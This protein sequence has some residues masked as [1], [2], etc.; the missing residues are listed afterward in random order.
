MRS[1]RSSAG[2]LLPLLLILA[3]TAPVLFALLRV[4]PAWTL[5]VGM[6]GDARYLENVFLPETSN[7]IPFRWSSPG[8]RITV[9]GA[10]SA[11]QVF[12]LRAHGIAQ[13]RQDDQGGPHGGRVVRMES[14]GKPFARSGVQES[15]GWRVYRVLLPE[16]AL[17]NGVG[18]PEPLGL[19]I[20]S[21]FHEYRALGLAISE[22]GLRPLAGVAAPVAIPLL[23]ALLYT[24]LLAGVVG[25]LW[26]ADE[27]FF[28]KESS[29]QERARRLSVPLAIAAL[30]L[31]VWAW[32]APSTLAG[33]VP[34]PLWVLVLGGLGITARFWMHWPWGDR[35]EGRGNRGQGKA[36][37][38]VFIGLFL[39]ALA[40]LMYE[41]L[42]T[43][44]FS[45]TM[46]YHF[47]FIAI[48]VA[49][50]GMTLGAMIVYLLPRT[51]TPARA[52]YHLTLYGLLFGITT[53][54]SFL[55]HMSIPFI[56]QREYVETVVG[57]Y[58]MAL[59]YIVIAVPF[60]MSGICV[61]L[62]LTK[63]P[64][65]VSKLYGA[66][67]A[68]AAI[69]CML[70]IVTLRY[71]S[72]PTA[73]LVVALLACVGAAF[74]GIQGTRN[75]GQETGSREQGMGDRGQETGSRGAVRLLTRI[76][77]GCA[78]V[79]AVLVVLN[80]A[81]VNQQDSP[82]RLLWVRGEK[83]PKPLY[84]KW[85]SF[86][87]IT[88][89][90]NPYERVAPLGWGMSAATPPDTRARQLWLTIDAGAATAITAFHGDLDDVDHLKYDVTN[91]V[92]SIR[93][94]ARVLVVGSGG[95]RDVLSALLFGQESVT[96]VDINEHTI[97]AIN[98]EFGNFTG[99]LDTYPSVQFVHDEARS[100]IARQDEPF[101]I[102]QISLIDTWAATTAGAFVLTENSLYTIEAWDTFLE[103]LTPGGVLT[104][105][106]WYFGDRP[107]EMYRL[108][109]LAAAAL[110]RQGIET[111]RDHI[112]IVKSKEI[113]GDAEGVGTILLSKQPFSPADVA[114][115]EAVCE[116]MRFGVVLSP[117]T[118]LDATFET[119]TS[120]DNFETFVASYL[121]NI[122]PPTDDSPFFFQMLRLRDI[123]NE[124]LLEQGMMSFNMHA[125]RI[126]GYLIVIVVVLAFL[127][128]VLPLLLTL[129]G[130]GNRLQVTEGRERGQDVRRQA[131]RLRSQ[132]DEQG[133][134]DQGPGAGGAVSLFVFFFC[135]G[136]GFMLVEIS[137]MQRL[138][139][140]LG[141][142]TYS[143]SVVLFT[144]LLS[145]GLGSTLTERVG[146]ERL[147]RAGRVRFALLLAVLVVFGLLT[148]FVIGW[149]DSAQTLVRIL[150]AVAIL[151]PLGVFMG[152][153]FP[154][155]M[156]VAART[157]P[158]LAPWLW[159]VN[160]AT[161]V[162]ASVFA[163]AIALSS[164]ISTAFWIGSLFYVGALLSFSRGAR[165]G[166][167]GEGTGER[168]EGTGERGEGTGDKEQGRGGR[169]VET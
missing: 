74:F 25:L 57:I 43:R 86:S 94:D 14:D 102:I 100:Y 106:R 30:L 13:F 22:V 90:G 72:G 118:A 83:E 131:G 28:V 138:I 19:V 91:L 108:T 82:F 49:M 3:L 114:T 59:T 109:S 5:N 112:I 123:F 40:T 162:C 76:A 159:G 32:Q 111:P 47:A 60:V 113:G 68:G 20:P 125:V 79:L 2:Y 4:P 134:G 21:H 161:S 15:G 140:F 12:S 11:R 80:T 6:P 133:P 137:Q 17:V 144:L 151:F 31:I 55:T 110:Q 27:R 145:S 168:G 89:R 34:S 62:A 73:V 152:M 96:G 150:I 75:R 101:D 139:V 24:W 10:S 166:E 71:T 105:S 141:H 29:T 35:G 153:A 167:R 77:L 41:N 81:L 63:F 42:L 7:G 36:G 165:R 160:G 120:G 38:G 146:P 156:K 142:P 23:R 93:S 67:L 66:D 148:P 126:L 51:F 127:F 64:R 46:W 16:G 154:L 119:L 99:Y 122:A 98:N 135:I 50:F 164:S 155:G 92:H 65:Q 48:S 18:E 124:D 53:V 128:I 58:S 136:A 149:F 132:E 104:V 130:R 9:P 39:V 85:N 45:V 129:K 157:S 26:Y 78:G 107:G 147:A 87:R 54:L 69:G 88:I 117:N 95:G 70:V 37:R 163:V 143:L 115:I 158:D 61:T 116:R 103:H 97:D 121:I 8:T 84:E 1:Y 33:V 52:P 169:N 44:I 56:T